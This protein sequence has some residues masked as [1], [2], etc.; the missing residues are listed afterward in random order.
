M[1]TKMFRIVARLL[2]AGL[3]IVL[4]C[5]TPE[6]PASPTLQETILT[7]NHE[8]Y[9][10]GKACVENGGKQILWEPGDEISVF[11]R[12]SGA[13]FTSQ[14]TANAAT[15]TFK[16]TLATLDGVTEDTFYGDILWGLYPYRADAVSD[17][18]SVTTT[19]P[20]EQV[21]RAGSFAP[22]THITLA[23]SDSY[24]LD[25]YNITGG[26][27]FSLTKSGIQSVTL[28]GADGEILAGKVQL[29]FLFG[30]PAI[31]EITE[32]AT[33][34][35]LTAPDGTFETGQWYY[36]ATLPTDFPKGFTLTFKTA[37]A[38]AQLSTASY[39][40]ITRGY[41]GSIPDADKNLVFAPTDDDEIGQ[42]GPLKYLYGR[43]I[44][45]QVISKSLNDGSVTYQDPKEDCDEIGYSFYADGTGVTWVISEAKNINN[46][47]DFTWTLT[48]NTLYLDIPSTHQ[49]HMPMGICTLTKDTFIADISVASHASSYNLR[50]FNVLKRSDAVDLGLSVKWATCNIGASFTE[51]YGD[52][53]AWGETK[54]KA[55]Y[56]WSTYKWCNGSYDKLTKYNP[57]YSYGTVDNKKVLEPA[58]DAATENWGHSWRTPT[59]D[60]WEEL[61][62]DCNWQWTTVQGVKGFLISGKKA[63]YT[64]K[65]IFLPA[66]GEK[67]GTDYSGAGSYG[68]YWSSNVHSTG[69]PFYARYI[70]F[71][72]SGPEFSAVGRSYGFSVRPVKAD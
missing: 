45:T 55:N 8:G 2:T 60:E 49:Q 58:D 9:A 5:C 32:P 72:S 48:G 69:M 54:P 28:K 61:A 53:F 6:S 47:Y 34:V 15:A 70:S 67:G 40:Y 66:A 11:F 25:F 23:A 21:G 57:Q 33:E 16:G 56:D 64:D 1:E 3:P 22:G 30:A 20:S 14:N 7:A 4:A 38:Q 71:T 35:T 44:N 31:Y 26:V 42:I 50:V 62:S 19:L 13:R 10:S 39:R 37:D 65:S 41:Y 18:T 46:R 43:W 17:G 59:T 12:G 63:G 68:T 52:Y 51:Q 24:N 36:I 27:R 29:G